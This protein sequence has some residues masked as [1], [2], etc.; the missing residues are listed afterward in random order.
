MNSSITSCTATRST[1]RD[2]ISDAVQ[3]HALSWTVTGGEIG[4]IEAKKHALQGSSITF[5]GVAV[6]KLII[7]NGSDGGDVPGHYVFTSTGLSF[8]DVTVNSAVPGTQVTING[9][10]RTFG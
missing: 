9:E 10:T 3:V 4:A 7:D 5:T 6:G 2:T 8:N 1:S